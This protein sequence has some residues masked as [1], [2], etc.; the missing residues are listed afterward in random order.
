MNTS[1]VRPLFLVDKSALARSHHPAVGQRLAP[2]YPSAQVATCPII[3]LELLFSV[4]NHNEHAE[5]R[6]ELQSIPSFPIDQPIT[7]RAIEVQ[8]MLALSGQHRV[9]ITD[10]LIAAV[11]EINNLTILHY[12]K[13][14]DTIAQTTNQ[15]TQ[16]IAPRGTL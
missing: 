5:L 15:P 13:D 1:R 3:D 16:W 9:P 6:Q 8:G 14:F 12:D 2:L 4:R 11:A 7:D 10:L